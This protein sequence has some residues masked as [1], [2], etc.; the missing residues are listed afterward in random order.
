MSSMKHGFSENNFNVF[1]Q[2]LT[3]LNGQAEGLLDAE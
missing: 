1:I 2:D 3:G